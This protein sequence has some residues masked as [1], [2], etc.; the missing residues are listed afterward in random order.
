MRKQVERLTVTY[1]NSIFLPNFSSELY[2]A[3]QVND[4]D[5]HQNSSH[6]AALLP[7]G[8]HCF[9]KGD[10]WQDVCQQTCDKIA[11]YWGVGM[12]YLLNL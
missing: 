4:W 5:K 8:F 11:C 7:H 12:S 6:N 9:T 2:P 1:F 10:A 3:D